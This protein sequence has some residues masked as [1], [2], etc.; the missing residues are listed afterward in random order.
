ME[1]DHTFEFNEQI[2]HE[3]SQLEDKNNDLLPNLKNL[4]IIQKIKLKIFGYTFIKENKLSG[5]KNSLP[6]YALYCDKHG[7]QISYPIGWKRKLVC[8]KCLQ[9]T[10]KSTKTY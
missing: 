1:Y 8:P 6:F 5:W 9:E 4:N 10:I 3:F 2:H 7:L